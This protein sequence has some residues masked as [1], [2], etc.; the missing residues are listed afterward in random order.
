MP[1]KKEGFMKN[2]C[3]KVKKLDCC[4]IKLIKWSTVAFTFFLITV[5]P[6]LAGIVFSVHWV[7]WLLIGIV[8]MIKPLLKYFS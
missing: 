7:I 2:H 6:W 5:W 8:L 1:K 4:D 3:D